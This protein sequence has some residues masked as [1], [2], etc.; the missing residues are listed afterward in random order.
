MAVTEAHYGQILDQMS[1]YPETEVAAWGV[2]AMRLLR[3]YFGIEMAIRIPILLGESI[4]PRDGIN[5]AVE[6]VNTLRWLT[7]AQ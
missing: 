2:E 6:Y 1:K 7:P 3:K 5:K 4:D